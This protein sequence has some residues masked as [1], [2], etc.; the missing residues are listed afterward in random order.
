MRPITKAFSFL[1]G[2]MIAGLLFGVFR[3]RRG[4]DRQVAALKEAAETPGAVVDPR[5]L[6]FLPPPVSRYFRHVLAEGQRRIR[7]ARFTQEGTIRTDPESSR[8]LPFQAEQVVSLQPPGFLWNARVD[9]A[10]LLHVRVLDGYHNGQGSS[11]VRLL[12]AVS[13]ARDRDRPEI[14]AAALH[15]YLAE[16][17][18]Y[19]TA[20][21][22][23][24]GV[25]WTAIDDT[26]ALA[27][28]TD[29]DVT[30]SLE[31]RFNAA[32]EAAGIYTPGRWRRVAVGYEQ[33]PW[34]GHFHAYT[35]RGGMRVPSGG[36]VAWYLSGEWR[37]VWRG[38][39]LGAE[40]A[41]H[42][43]EE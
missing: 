40:Y 5:P 33:T 41:F 23:Q 35:E 27:T 37:E 3:G 25:R 9:M 17:V 31:F 39:L 8:W 30:V 12:S 19:P 10:P 29:R 2:G 36:D 34:E 28:L 16:A 20:L 4:L 26:R 1:S 42:A 38:R 14:N 11:Q 21:L 24:A 13:V 43:E 18:W 7:W 32:G 15:R 22:P 6:D